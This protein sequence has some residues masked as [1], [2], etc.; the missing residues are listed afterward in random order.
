MKNQKIEQKLEEEKEGEWEVEKII[1][2][3]KKHKKKE[4]LIKWVG[5]SKPTWEPESNL[6]NCQELLKD[7]LLEEVVKKCSNK[8]KKSNN[9]PKAGRKRKISDSNN[10][11]DQ[12]TLSKSISHPKKKCRG[13]PK[14]YSCQQEEDTML[15]DIEILDDNAKD[16]A[17]IK[18][19]DET[20]NKNE[21]KIIDEIKTFQIYNPIE[22]KKD[23]FLSL[24]ENGPNKIENGKDSDSIYLE[25]DDENDKISVNSTE[26]KGLFTFL[27]GKEKICPISNNDTIL[28][29]KDEEE[30]ET[31]SII[32]IL[33][34]K[35]PNNRDE[36]IKLNIKYKKDNKLY[37]EEFDTKSN[38]I[39][40][41]DVNKYY[42]N[43]LRDML[44]G[45]NYSK[46]LC[47]DS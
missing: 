7:F 17:E 15:Y 31:I 34:M 30:N 13:V 6:V 5:Y 27:Q 32:E 40:V 14:A 42:E 1:K 33:G 29:E 38:Q 19:K 4:Y 24:E 39:S 28:E 43:V 11:E 46:S 23:E 9:L 45:Q 37:I 47:F 35:I 12:S 8:D 36:S 18:K 16:D 10:G 25:E 2:Q 26:A 44:K 21:D 41:E 22:E 20:L 3:R